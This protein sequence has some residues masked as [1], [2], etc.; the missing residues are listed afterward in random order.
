[1]EIKNEIKA[2][3]KKENEVNNMNENLSGNIFSIRMKRILAKVYDK[4]A[5]LINDDKDKLIILNPYLKGLFFINLY[6]AAISI[7]PGLITYKIV[8]ILLLIVLFLTRIIILKY[9]KK[10]F[11]ELEQNK[12][13]SKGWLD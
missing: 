5:G 12:K 3:Y 4:C 8:G 9:G 1:M 6:I 13:R 11:K 2:F 10:Y 7:F